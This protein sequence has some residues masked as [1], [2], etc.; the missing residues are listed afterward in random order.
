MANKARKIEGEVAVLKD[1]VVTV[2]PHGLEMEA[3]P[4]SLTVKQRQTSISIPVF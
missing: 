1:K 4:Y 3:Q 2:Q